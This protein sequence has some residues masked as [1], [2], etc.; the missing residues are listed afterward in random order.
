MAPHERNE[1]WAGH[2][3]EGS[4]K[5]LQNAL[6][7]GKIHGAKEGVGSHIPVGRKG[8]EEGG[9]TPLLFRNFMLPTDFPTTYVLDMYGLG[10][11]CGMDL[12]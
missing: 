3:P 1:A 2:G 10:G 4:G 5:R 11:R 8:G 6:P 7:S 12:P 9:P